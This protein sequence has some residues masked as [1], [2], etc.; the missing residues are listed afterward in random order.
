MDGHPE[1]EICGAALTHEM[2]AIAGSCSGTLVIAGAGSTLWDDIRRLGD[3]KADWMAINEAG[4]ALPFEF[5]HWASM[6]PQLFQHWA[7]FRGCKIDNGKYVPSGNWHFHGNEKQP[8]VRTIWRFENQ[9]GSSGLYGVRVG[10]LLGYERIIL[11]G[12]PY[13]GPRFFDPPWFDKIDIASECGLGP[14]EDFAKIN[15]GRVRSMSG[16]TR[17][18]L[19]EP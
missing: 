7:L 15:N 11:V 17:R 8:L 5:R 13:M 19:G 4:F 12:C 10:L 9:M 18:I 14:W 3:I 6:H 16:H 2:P 1:L